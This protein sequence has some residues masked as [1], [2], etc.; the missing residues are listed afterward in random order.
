MGRGRSFRTTSFLFMDL[1]NWLTIML[2][3][4]VDASFYTQWDFNLAVKKPNLFGA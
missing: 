4:D 2:K 3:V 1:I